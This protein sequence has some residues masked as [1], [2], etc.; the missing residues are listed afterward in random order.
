MKLLEKL[1]LTPFVWNL[2]FDESRA[3]DGVN[4]R[5]RFI[6]EKNIHYSDI[7]KLEGA[8]SILEMLVALS[9]R[10]EEEIM[11]D[12]MIG[13]RTYLW[14]WSM[15]ENMDISEID[16]S[17]F[18]KHIAFID[19]SIDI[20]QYRKYDYDGSHGALFVVKSPKED[21][22]KTDIWYQMMWWLSENFTDDSDWIF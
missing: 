22:R 17:S 13:D 19:S 11:A 8:C 2:E 1:H 20:M 4:L 9:I 18:E 5:D 16:D 6:Y 14:F 12:S 15:L 7:C 10:C 3:I 21:L